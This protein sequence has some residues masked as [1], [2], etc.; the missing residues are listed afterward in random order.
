MAFPCAHCL[1]PRTR[2]TRTREV[3]RG[4]IIRRFRRCLDCG[5]VTRTDQ[6]KPAPERLAGK[7]RPAA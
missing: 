3:Q 1:S 2:V 4:R 7:N 5:K 6:D